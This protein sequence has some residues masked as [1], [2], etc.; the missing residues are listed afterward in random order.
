[1]ATNAI[2][3]LVSEIRDGTVVLPD[4]QR[5]FVWKEDQIRLLLEPLAVPGAVSRISEETLGA[6]EEETQRL[7]SLGEKASVYDRRTAD[8][9]FHR[10]ICEA[11]GNRVLTQTLDP[12]IRKVLLLTT[13]GFRYGR[14]SRSF[15]EHLEVLKA[16]R[17][18]DE[19]LTAQRLRDHLRTALKFNVDVW[20]RR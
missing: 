20:E 4:L 7:I 18:R 13:V 1:M 11:S 16:L 6:L 19:A 3:S 9:Q 2:L 5:D 14:A 15:E 12:L 8:Y 17:A 10:S